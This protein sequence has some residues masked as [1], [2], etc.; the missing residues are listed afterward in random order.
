LR[1]V[2]GAAP[3]D[4]SMPAAQIRGHPPVDTSKSALVPWWFINTSG[5]RNGLSQVRLTPW[6]FEGSK[7]PLHPRSFVLY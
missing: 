1:P 2:I 4:G 5:Q 6:R 3:D 7:N